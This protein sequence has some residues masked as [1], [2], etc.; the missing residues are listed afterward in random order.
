M[1]NRYLVDLY[2]CTRCDA[3]CIFNFA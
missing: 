3:K 2:L 1:S